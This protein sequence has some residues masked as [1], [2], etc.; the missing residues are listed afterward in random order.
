MS[1]RLLRLHMVVLEGLPSSS[2]TS[3]ESYLPPGCGHSQHLPLCM[4]AHQERMAFGGRPG[5]AWNRWGA[6][7]S[8]RPSSRNKGGL[9]LRGGEGRGRGKGGEGEGGPC[10]K[11]LGGR[12]PCYQKQLPCSR[13]RRLICVK[14]SSA[15]TIRRARRR[16]T[17]RSY[18]CSS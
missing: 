7:R 8:P 3:T 5:S 2:L 6:K 9:L 15:A 11:V 16:F 14:A 18:S 1:L 13:C 10:S 17:L 4:Y 12:R